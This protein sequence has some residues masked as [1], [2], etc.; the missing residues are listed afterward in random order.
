MLYIYTY[1][2]ISAV[3]CSS[4][5]TGFIVW[6]LAISSRLVKVQTGRV[7]GKMCQKPWNLKM[8]TKNRL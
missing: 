7:I 2:Y 5:I 6:L 1:I 3:H 4:V 8:N